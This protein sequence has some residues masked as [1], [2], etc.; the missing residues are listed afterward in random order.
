MAPSSAQ[1]VA[2]GKVTVTLPSGLTVIRRI[3][4]LEIQLSQ[5]RETLCT[6]SCR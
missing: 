5:P 1:S 2:T 6:P 4:V 3:D